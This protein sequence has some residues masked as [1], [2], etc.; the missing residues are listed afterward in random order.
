MRNSLALRVS[1]GA[2][3]CL[4]TVGAQAQSSAGLVLRGQIQPSACSVALTDGTVDFGLRAFS[5]LLPNGTILGPL[6]TTLEIRCIS[7]TSVSF[8]ASDNR[9]SSAISSADVSVWPSTDSASW[10]TGQGKVFGLGRTQASASA[11][12]VG[13]VAIALDTPGILLDQAP[14][15]S[16]SRRLL[17]SPKRGESASWGGNLVTSQAILATDLEYTFGSVGTN[18]RTNARVVTLGAITSA[19][20]PLVLQAIIASRSKLMP[21]DEILLDGSLTFTLRYL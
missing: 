15:S 18:T 14:L 8:S 5:S 1:T 21:S 10:D 13:A 11:P 16:G 20:V 7:P 6:R 3:T 9:A 4:I 12:K 2:I 19:S 17:R